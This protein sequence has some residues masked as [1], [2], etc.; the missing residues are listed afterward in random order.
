MIKEVKHLKYKSSR[1]FFKKISKDFNLEEHNKKILI[2]ACEC[3]DQINTGQ[4]ILEKE[5]NYYKNRFEELRPNP[6]LKEI[7]DNKSIFLR[8]MK[9]LNLDV[10]F[11]TEAGAGH[12][13]EY[14]VKKKKSKRKQEM[15]NEFEKL[16]D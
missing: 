8:Y 6:A 12:P 1:E 3:L 16:L 15:D 14:L 10:E 13:P 5:G 7:K 2:L 9:Q 4:K 11:R